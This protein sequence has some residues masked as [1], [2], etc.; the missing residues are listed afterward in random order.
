MSILTKL[1]DGLFTQSRNFVNNFF[2]IFLT[3]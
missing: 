1:N 3:Q 2:Y